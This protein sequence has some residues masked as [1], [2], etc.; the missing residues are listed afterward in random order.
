MIAIIENARRRLV[1]F[2]T[3][4]FGQMRCPFCA[5]IINVADRC[6]RCGNELEDGGPF[7]DEDDGE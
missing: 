2:L 1:D 3:R 6:P 4:L 5:S 7:E